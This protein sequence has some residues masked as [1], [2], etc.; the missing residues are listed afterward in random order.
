MSATLDVRWRKGGGEK[1]AEC[2]CQNIPKRH[3]KK[4][5]KIRHERR[6]KC[7]EM[8]E[9]NMDVLKIRELWTKKTHNFLTRPRKKYQKDKKTGH[10]KGL[11]ACGR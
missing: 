10:G 2:D 4:R 1:D 7:A 5:K 3:G 11:G 9:R 8:L 6:V